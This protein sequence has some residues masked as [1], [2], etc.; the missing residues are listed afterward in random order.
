MVPPN[1]DS[2]VTGWAWRAQALLF[3]M[4][5]TLVDS[6]SVVEG[7]WAEFAHRYDLD[8][9][10]VISYAH[11][12]QTPDT[13]ARFL[14]SG[15]DRAAVVGWLEAEEL[16]RMDGVIEIAGAAALLATLDETAAAVAVVTSAPR[17]LALRR[18]RAAGI[19]APSLVVTAEDVSSGK[20]SPEGYVR[21]ATALGRRP[22]D[23]VVFEDAE[24]GIQAA[25]AAGAA[26]VV[27]GGHVGPA[28]AGLPRIRDFRQLTVTAADSG[29]AL[30][31]VSPADVPFPA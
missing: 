12:R 25:L 1:G 24:A 4:D 10:V 19:R 31:E 5:G 8:P 14:P 17:E 29:D 16:G 21:A 20:P 30:L 27:V 26:T 11:G 7:L 13:V 2:L 22:Q 28:T 18:L 9:A 3:D 6:T 15:V 23:C